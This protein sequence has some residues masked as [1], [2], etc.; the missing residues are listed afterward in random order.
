MTANQSRIA[1]QLSSRVQTVRPSLARRPLRDR[2]G[3]DLRRERV[4]EHL[5]GQVKVEVDTS[6]RHVDIVEVP[7]WGGVGEP[8][9]FPVARL[10]HTKSTGLWVVSRRDRD[11]QFHEHE[12][13]RKPPTMNVQVRLDHID[14]SGDPIFWG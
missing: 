11:L 13:K 12:H 9:R 1:E 4:L 8:T 2:R 6:E 10:R 14:S 3:D 5:R 7:P